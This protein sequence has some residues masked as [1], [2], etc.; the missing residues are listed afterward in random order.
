MSGFFFLGGDNFI[1]S[2]DSSP[3]EYTE[4]GLRSGEIHC[5]G[6]KAEKKIL[7]IN[8]AHQFY[9]SNC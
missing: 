2:E 8:F 4:S 5:D 6:K 3:V 9:R 7:E 1:S